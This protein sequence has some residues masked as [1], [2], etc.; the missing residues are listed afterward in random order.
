MLRATRAAPLAFYLL[1]AMIVTASVQVVGVYLVFA[2]LILP[3]L[4]AGNRLWLAYATGITAYAAG[5]LGS[6]LFDLPA[7]AT[8]VLML[9]A[10]SLPVAA[11]SRREAP[12]NASRA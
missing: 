9:A 10:V 5:L 6:A 11:G 7:G 4:A 3:A 2:S 1:F 8:I 12:E